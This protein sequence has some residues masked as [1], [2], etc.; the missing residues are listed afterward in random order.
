MRRVVVSAFRFCGDMRENLLGSRQ[1]HKPLDAKRCLK[2]VII[3][4]SL[5]FL[6][7]L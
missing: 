2:I 6:M 7:L 3:H 4:V 5:N 1:Q